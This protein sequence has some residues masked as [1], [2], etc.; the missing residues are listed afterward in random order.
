VHGQ[1]RLAEGD[2]VINDTV[3]GWRLP[4]P[5]IP[6]GFINTVIL[7][8]L[9]SFTF[10]NDGVAPGHQA[11]PRRRGVARARA[12]RRAAPRRRRL[13]DPRRGTAAAREV[14]ASSRV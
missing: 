6:Q 5:A 10:K 12:G 9:L 14:G 8:T 4:L 3:I 11:C 1:A 7:L 13:P 2:T